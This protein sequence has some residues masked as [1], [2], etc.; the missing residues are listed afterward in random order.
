MNPDTKRHVLPPLTVDFL[1]QSNIKIDNVF[2]KAWQQIGFKSLL[3]R[4]GFKKR[5]GT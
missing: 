4:C 3:H 5:S 2:S 1:A